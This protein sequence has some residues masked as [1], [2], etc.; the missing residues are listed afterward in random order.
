LT[1]RGGRGRGRRRPAP[2]AS[3]WNLGELC[4]GS[5]QAQVLDQPLGEGIVL[6]VALQM[7]DGVGATDRIGLAQ[8]VVAQADL[9]VGVGA[10]DV[11]QGGAGSRAHL[12]GG[13]PKQGPDVLVALPPFEQKLEHRALFIRE[14]H[15]RD[16]VGQ[17]RQ[18]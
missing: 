10:A 1:G 12:V 7:T 4:P 8:Q 2:A 11:T 18:D 16:S 14:R 15:G 6:G 3:F 13:D 9:G 5:E 17:G